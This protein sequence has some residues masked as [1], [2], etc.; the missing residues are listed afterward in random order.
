[1]QADASVSG[2]QPGSNQIKEAQDALIEQKKDKIVEIFKQS[3]DIHDLVE[4]VKNEPFLADYNMDVNQL[5]GL[6]F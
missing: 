6:L 1:M 4:G 2:A 3:T 5:L